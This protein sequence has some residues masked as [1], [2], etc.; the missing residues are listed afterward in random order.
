MIYSQ[1]LAQ[2]AEVSKLDAIF[3]KFGVE[4]ALFI[5]QLINV[6]LVFVLLKI[7]A[8]KPILAMLEERKQ[9]I[10]EGEAKLTRIEQQLA[11]TDE[12][13][14]AALDAANAKASELIEEAK[15]SSEALREQ[16]TAEA[17]N[18]AQQI[19][20]RAEE[21]AAQIRTE[22][23]EKL[24]KEFGQ[25]VVKTTAQITGKELDAND[26]ARLNQEAMAKIEA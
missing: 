2:A 17:A 19:V 5:A 16:K 21:A 13:T 3:D 26:Q 9:R 24:R 15:T 20:K 10:A 18:S 8:F 4:W 1:I 12:R 6:V 14:Q 11:E 22:E 25:L 7:F 23:V